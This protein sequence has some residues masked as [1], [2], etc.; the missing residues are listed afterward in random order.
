[1]LSDQNL[2]NEIAQ[3]LV[4]A[5]PNVAK[6]IMMKAKLWPEGDVC[7][8]EFDYLTNDNQE[9][10]FDPD[11]N[12]TRDLRK[13]LVKLRKFYIENNLTNGKPIWHGCEVIVDLEKNKIHVDFKYD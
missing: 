9:N 6:K 3:I 8:F 11:A 1:M 2:Y 5:G 13:V 7:E 4:N 12:A 10:W